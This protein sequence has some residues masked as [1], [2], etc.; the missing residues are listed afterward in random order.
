M[1]TTDGRGYS[2][3]V[4]TFRKYNRTCWSILLEIVSGIPSRDL[5]R[6]KSQ[7]TL[8]TRAVK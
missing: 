7:F 3:L 4:V 6:A 5:V 2:V 8:G 1:A